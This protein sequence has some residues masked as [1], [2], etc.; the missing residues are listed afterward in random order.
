[1]TSRGPSSRTDLQK[2]RL[3]FDPVGE[4]KISQ[5]AGFSFQKETLHILHGVTQGDASKE[6]DEAHILFRLLWGRNA[7]FGSPAMDEASIFGRL[8]FKTNNRDT[9]L[10]EKATKK[11][12]KDV[13]DF[14][15]SFIL[16]EVQ[17]EN[18]M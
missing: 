9:K 10:S 4:F 15:V 18:K 11:K 16:D 7:Y 3:D 14:G 5:E 17:A 2:G 8:L 13:R 1:M 6:L 12:N